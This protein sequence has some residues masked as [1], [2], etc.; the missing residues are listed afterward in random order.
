MNRR[1]DRARPPRARSQDGAAI[2]LIVSVTIALV[3][4][5]SLVVD[6]GKAMV[7]RKQLQ[8]AADAAAL[9]G[10]A[11]FIDINTFSDTG[12]TD[13][14]RAVLRQN[15]FLN[16]YLQDATFTIVRWNLDMSRVF[17]P[18]DNP[19]ARVMPALKVTVTLANNQNYGPLPMSFA[20]IVGVNQ[21]NVVA[22]A[23]AMKSPSIAAIGSLL[24]IA[25]NSCLYSLLWDEAHQKPFSTAPV[26]IYSALVTSQ[27]NVTND[28]VKCTSG[29][30]TSL[31]VVNN[32]ANAVAQLLATGNTTTY[33]S[34][35]DVYIQPGDKTSVYNDI[36]AATAGGQVI[37]G[38]LPVTEGDLTVKGFL[39]T[40]KFV[41]F[42]IMAGQM[43]NV[44][45]G[46]PYS[47]VSGRML[48]L[49]E[50]QTMIPESQTRD[51][52]TM[53]PRLVY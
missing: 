53:A 17:M 8:N 35:D 15:Q 12:V 33:Y 44:P 6:I 9:A 37:A 52:M 21:M 41:P 51:A 3:M 46:V 11:K 27:P 10:A 13:A 29:Q 20:G 23:T 30:W 1:N 48:T 25:I 47:Y 19:Y 40:T 4:I 39:N 18:G 22:T 26:M 31:N 28:M 43:K 36:Q 32:S 7:V 16:T 50:A 49:Q 42:A 45:G 2:S 38:Y 5:T 14:A 24:P 34:S